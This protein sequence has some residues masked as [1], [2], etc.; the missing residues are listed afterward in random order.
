VGFTL[1]LMV[2]A[3]TSAAYSL[4]WDWW[5]HSKNSKPKI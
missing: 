1:V 4:I 3:G 2:L 5:R